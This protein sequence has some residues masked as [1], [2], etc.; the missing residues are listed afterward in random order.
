V[1]SESILGYRPTDGDTIVGTNGIT[2]HNPAM[3][4]STPSPFDP[5]WMISF[6]IV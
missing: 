4:A 3:A 1:R 6:Q 5:S 2:G